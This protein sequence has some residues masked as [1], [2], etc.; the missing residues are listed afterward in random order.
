MLRRASLSGF[1]ECKFKGQINY[2]SA[3]K[4]ESTQ[5]DQV[6]DAH[7]LQQT[8]SPAHWTTQVKVERVCH[9]S[10]TRLTLELLSAQCAIRD[11]K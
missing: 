6:C 8:L 5:Q 10:N 4:A 11:Q 9:R 3:V 1:N 7:H 2:N